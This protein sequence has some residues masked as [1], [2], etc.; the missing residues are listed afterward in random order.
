MYIYSGMHSVLELACNF[1]LHDRIQPD[2]G[3]D[4]ESPYEID[5]RSKALLEV[6]T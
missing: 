2:V 4:C 1:V 5:A 3:F 6:M